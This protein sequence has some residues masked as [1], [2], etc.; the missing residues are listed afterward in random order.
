MDFAIIWIDRLFGYRIAGLKPLPES[1]HV[2]IGLWTR[3]ERHIVLLDP[4][5]EL[6]FLRWRQSS[7]IAIGWLR[8]LSVSR[9]VGVGAAR[10]FVDIVIAHL[11]GGRSVHHGTGEPS[12]I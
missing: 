4:T 9:E 2:V 8:P 10:I 11:Y 7:L 3:I 1:A 6:L 5:L 12:G